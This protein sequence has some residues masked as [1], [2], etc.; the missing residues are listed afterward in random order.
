MVFILTT[1]YRT[2]CSQYDY[3]LLLVCSQYDYQLQLQSIITKFQVFTLFSLG[4]SVDKPTATGLPLEN[5]SGLQS[6]PRAKFTWLPP[7]LVH[8]LSQFVCTLLEQPARR[9][10][11]VCFDSNISTCDNVLFSVIFLTIPNPCVRLQNLPISRLT[12]A[13]LPWSWEEREE[14]WP[15]RWEECWPLILARKDD[16][17]FCALHTVFFYALI[18]L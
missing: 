17:H 5:P 15:W 12:S 4:Q 10:S 1:N 13:A 2:V 7:R 18:T 16:L 3:Q 8:R 14:A 11:G 9:P 6:S